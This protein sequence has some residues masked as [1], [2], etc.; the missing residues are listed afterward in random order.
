MTTSVTQA[1]AGQIGALRHMPAICRRV[2]SVAALGLHSG[3]IISIS[4]GL[5]P[6]CHAIAYPN[7]ILWIVAICSTFDPAAVGRG[8]RL[9]CPSLR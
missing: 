1:A 8:V 9:N 2:L 7:P 4:F 5:L 6:N 3:A